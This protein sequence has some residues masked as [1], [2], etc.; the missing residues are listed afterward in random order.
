MFALV[1]SLALS[2]VETGIRSIIF[3]IPT[4]LVARWCDVPPGWKSVFMTFCVIWNDCVFGG[5]K[6]AAKPGDP[7]AVGN[8]K[9]AA[10]VM[11]PAQVAAEARKS[12]RGA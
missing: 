4:V 7:P 6:D 3:M 2:G 1:E 5:K 8:R 10:D 12:A 9:A 11:T